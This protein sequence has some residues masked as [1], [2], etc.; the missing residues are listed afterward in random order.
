MLS[1]DGSSPE[2]LISEKIHPKTFAWCQRYNKAIQA[3]KE[4]GPEPEV[5][6]GAEALERVSKADFHEPNNKV[7][8]SDPLKLKS[9]QKVSVGPTDTGFTAREEGN[10]VGLDAEQAV[11]GSK[12]EKGADIHIHNP[13][14]NF[15]VQAA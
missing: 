4:A 12:T 14:F 9:G 10:L 3:A 5:I 2:D 7:A 1:L 15:S 13:R 8:D 6:E 11:V